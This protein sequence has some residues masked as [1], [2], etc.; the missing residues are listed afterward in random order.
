MIAGFDHA[1]IPIRAVDS[2]LEFY[3]KLGFKI[4]DNYGPL[5]YSVH[6]NENKINF[7]TPELWQSE[8]FSLRGPTAQPGCGDFCFVWNDTE[9]ALSDY[10]KKSECRNCG[11]ACR[12]KRWP[13]WWTSYRNKY[14]YSGSRF[15]FVGVHHL[16]VNTLHNQLKNPTAPNSGIFVALRQATGNA[17]TVSVQLL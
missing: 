17:I 3:R 15:K 14:L 13:E 8:K 1:A 7:H 2:M 11:R 5:V 10:V 16:L 4:S 12:S 6:F 9:Q